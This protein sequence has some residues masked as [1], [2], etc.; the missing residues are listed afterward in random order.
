MLSLEIP[1]RFGEIFKGLEVDGMGLNNY[2]TIVLLL[3]FNIIGC[4]TVHAYQPLFT[5]VF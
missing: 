1:E 2:V 5:A 3:V 4:L